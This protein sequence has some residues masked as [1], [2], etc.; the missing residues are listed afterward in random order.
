MYC[1]V[2]SLSSG[3]PRRQTGA[4]EIDRPGEI[5]PPEPIRPRS[6][7]LRTTAAPGVAEDHRGRVPPGHPHDAAAR[8]RAAAAEV[9]VLDGRS[10]VAVAGDRPEG[11][12]LIGR[13]LPLHDVAAEEPEALLDVLRCQDLQMLDGAGKP[14]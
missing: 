2:P 6:E 7:S 9:E 14:G 5:S 11:E 13:E 4:P 12:Q 1:I 10:V 8:M 3:S